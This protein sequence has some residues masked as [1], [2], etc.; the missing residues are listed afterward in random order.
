MGDICFSLRYV[1]TA[2]KLTVLIIEA[3]VLKKMEVEGVCN[4][5]VKITLML[6]GI[7]AAQ[8]HLHSVTFFCTTEPFR[9][10]GN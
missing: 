5:Y 2:R 9:E 10:T 8:P 4:A 6:V 1:P 3:N 7:Y